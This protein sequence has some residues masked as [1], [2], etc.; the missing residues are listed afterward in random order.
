MRDYKFIEQTNFGGKMNNLINV[1]F[2]KQ[3][4]SVEEQM[5][6][7]RKITGKKSRADRRS[8]GKNHQWD[9]DQDLIACHFAKNVRNV[10]EVER[11]AT[12][13]GIKPSA[14]K[15]RI[16][17]YRKLINHGMGVKDVPAQVLYVLGNFE[18]MKRRRLAS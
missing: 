13:L 18:S 6:I 8:F 9:T 2:R 4:L 11:M 7:I 16:S 12:T 1:D 15:A 14:F 5:N 10:D 3:T 17:S